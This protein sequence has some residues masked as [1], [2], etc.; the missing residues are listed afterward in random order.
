MNEQCCFCFEPVNKDD[1]ESWKQVMGWVHGKKADS[2]TLREYTGR[3]A[4]AGCIAKLKAGQ[5]PDQP[6]ML[7]DEA[8]MMEASRRPSLEDLAIAEDLFNSDN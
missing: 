6:S 8:T 5:A 2:M 4:H 7:D 3:F 1:P